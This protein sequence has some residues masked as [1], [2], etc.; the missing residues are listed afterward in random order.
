M[1]PDYFFVSNILQIVAVTTVAIVLGRPI[2]GAITKRLERRAAAE[3][4][5]PDALARIEARLDHLANGMEAMAV[6]VERISEGQRFTSKLLG[7]KK[8][9]LRVLTPH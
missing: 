9:E 2:I 8:A 5:S 7:E 1:T 4:A 6:E 3:P